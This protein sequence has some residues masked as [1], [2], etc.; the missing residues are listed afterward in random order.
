MRLE[1]KINNQSFV[2]HMTSIF[3]QPIVEKDIYGK[4]FKI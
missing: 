3:F 4:Q 2:S 1:K